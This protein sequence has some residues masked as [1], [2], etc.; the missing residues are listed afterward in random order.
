M[1]SELL[2]NV[3]NLYR[4]SGLDSTSV[5]EPLLPPS[6]IVSPALPPKESEVKPLENPSAEIVKPNLQ[7]EQSKKKDEK[8]PIQFIRGG[9][10]ITLPPIEAPA[11][12]SKKLQ[13]RND[14]PQHKREAV[15]KPEKSRYVIQNNFF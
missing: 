11:T 6:T 10:V 9:R 7:S 12:R 3:I 8:E 13:A 15:S 1:K 2:I 5:S 14:S 4:Q